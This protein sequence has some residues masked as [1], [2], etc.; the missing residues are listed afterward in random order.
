MYNRNHHSKYLKF[1]DKKHAHLSIIVFLAD[2]WKQ[3]MDYTKISSQSLS[4]FGITY[5]FQVFIRD[6]RDHLSEGFLRFLPRTSILIDHT[7]SGESKN[8]FVKNVQVFSTLILTKR[9]TNKI[10]QL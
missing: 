4:V 6:D 2:F 7:R 1:I 3:A 9:S 8:N 5:T 10:G